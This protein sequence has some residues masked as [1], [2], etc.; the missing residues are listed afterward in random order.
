MLEKNDG[1]IHP[2]P[3]S[4]KSSGCGLLTHDD[5][6]YIKVDKYEWKPNCEH[7]KHLRLCIG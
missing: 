1:V 2:H 6:N 4:N 7:S 3:N 5:K